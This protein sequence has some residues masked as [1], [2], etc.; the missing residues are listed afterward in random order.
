[1]RAWRLEALGPVAIALAAAVLGPG[2]LGLAAGAHAVLVALAVA[3]AV[4]AVGVRPRVRYRAWRY[5]V[6]ERE[7]R[8]RSGR[9]V[10]VRTLVPVA[11]IQHVELHQG[12]VQRRLG[13]ASVVLHTAAGA[14]A[15]PHLAAATAEDV[16]ARLATLTRESDAL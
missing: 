11:R 7:I 13:L 1:M 16:R 4:V 6:G 12:P 2:V 15:I 10:E 5:E 14:N 3:G 8:I 9:L